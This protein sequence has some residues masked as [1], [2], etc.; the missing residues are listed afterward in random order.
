MPLATRRVLKQF[1][2]A[3]YFDGVDDY[4][5]LPNIP[6]AGEVTLVA[7]F[8][9]INIYTYYWGT[10]F[11]WYYDGYNRFLLNHEGATGRQKWEVRFSNVGGSV[12]SFTSIPNRWVFA[13]G[14]YSASQGFSKFYWDMVLQGSIT[15]TP[16]TQPTLTPSSVQI[17]SYLTYYYFNG[18]IAQVLIYSRA[19]SDS[20]IAW[21]YQYPDNPVRNG[22]VLWLQA[23]PENVRDI[24][25]DGVLE[26]IDLSGYG[27]HGKIYGARLVGLV[28]TPRR[29]LS[30]ARVLQV[31]R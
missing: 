3:M 26:W 13:V 6:L 31:A 1:R 17:G 11:G 12:T 22:L 14:V 18:Y 21:N 15:F 19:L 7:W 16:F 30:P 28:K 8:W 24:D 29:L 9:D 4:V 25:G 23:S 2:Y 10:I 20:E 27:N 5:R